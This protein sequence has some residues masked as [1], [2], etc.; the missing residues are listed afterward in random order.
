MRIPAK[1]TPRTVAVADRR[2]KGG[3]RLPVGPSLVFAS[4]PGQTQA[5]VSSERSPPTSWETGH[6]LSHPTAYC[7]YHGLARCNHGR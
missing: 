3:A 7:R 4:G 2:N 6:S 5:P 1:E